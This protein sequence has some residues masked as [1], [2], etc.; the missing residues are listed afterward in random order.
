MSVLTL[1]LAYLVTCNESD[2]M[3]IM[4]SCLCFFLFFSFPP[5]L[6]PS[7]SGPARSTPSPPPTPAPP[8]PPHSGW[9]THHA[10]ACLDFV[11][12]FFLF[13]LFSFVLFVC[14]ETG[15]LYI[16]PLLAWV[17]IC[18][19]AWSQM[20]TG[21]KGMHVALYPAYIKGMH[22]ACTVSSLHLLGLWI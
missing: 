15:S 10:L 7:C 13:F 2:I 14:F 6:S 21:I 18:K 3:Y 22:V 8:N 11:F 12:C 1:E 17:L 9:Y 19:P 4:T 20:H 16:W 5:S